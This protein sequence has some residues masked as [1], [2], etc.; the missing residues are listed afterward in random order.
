MTPKRG[1]GCAGSGGGLSCA[2]PLPALSPLRCARGS[3]VSYFGVVVS[4]V[5]V[6][7]AAMWWCFLWCL[8]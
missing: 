2:A 4:V 6:V 7:V 5:V 8:R 3:G 1:P